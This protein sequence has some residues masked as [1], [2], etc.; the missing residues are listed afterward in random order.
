MTVVSAKSFLDGGGELGQLIREKDWSDTPL[1][2]PSTWPQSLRT[3]IR[4]ILTSR[5]PM[6]VWWGSELINIY[7]DAY[8]SI[9]GGKHP[10]ALGQPASVVWKE[11]WNEVE[12][13]AKTVM[14]ENTGTYDEAL[15]LLMDRNGYV[16]ETYYTFSY[17]PVP[18]DDG[19][20]QGIICAN[21][22]DTRRIMGERQLR[23]LREISKNISGVKTNHEIYQKSLQALEANPQDFPSVALYEI[24]NDGTQMKLVGD[25]YELPKSLAP[26]V[27][28]IEAQKEVYPELWQ[29]IQTGKIQTVSNVIE[30][31]GS[32]NSPFWEESP[33]DVLL[34]PILQP[35]HEFPFALL[36]VGLN[37][38]RL[39]DD[40][41]IDFFNL[42]AD[43]ISTALNNAYA[44]KREQKRAEALA[45]IDQAKTIFFSNISHEFRTPLTLMLGP[46][47]EMLNS[48]AE[49]FTTQDKGNLE[50]THRNAM[51]LLRLVNSLL[52]FSRIEAGR[53]KVKFRGICLGQY[54]ADLASSF[55]SL[56]DKVGLDF[57]I[58]TDVKSAVFVDTD[59]WE[60]IVLN[61]LSNAYKYT[62]S[63]KITVSVIESES[64]VTLTV[65]DTGTGIPESE[66]PHLFERFHRVKNA[67]GRSYE[68]SGIG[69][70][71]VKELVQLNHG[72]ISVQ[73]VEGEGTVFSIQ[74]P[75]GRKHLHDE[76]IATDELPD[77]IVPTRYSEEVLHNVPETD[78]VA[79]PKSNGQQYKILVA[80]DNA[81]MRDY[82]VKLLEKHYNV[83]LAENGKQ[84]LEKVAE[85]SPDLI[86]S[87]IMMPVMDGIEML[88]HVKS[89]PVTKHI[90]VLLLSARAGEEAKIEGYELGA[91]DYLVKPFSAK[92]LLARIHS[93]L[94]MAKTREHIDRQLHNVFMQAPVAICLLRGSDFIVETANQRILDIWGKDAETMLNRPVFEGIPEVARQGYRDLL[95][96]VYNSGETYIAEEM[97]LEVLRNGTAEKIYIKFVYEPFYEEDGTVSG[98]MV[99]AD[100]ITES[101][102][103]RNA[104]QA[105]E[106]RH[107]LAVEAARM[108]SFEWV[109]H[110]DSFIYSNRLAEIFGYAAATSFHHSDFV[111]KIHPDDLVTRNAAVN[112]AMQT[113]LLFYEARIIWDDGSVHWIRLNGKIENDATG[114]P[115]KMFGTVLDITN[116]KLRT[117][118]LQQKVIDRTQSLKEKD[119]ELRVSEER[120]QRMTEEVQDYAIILLDT[121]GT[122]LNWNRG[123]ENIKG[124]NEND[125]VGRSFTIFY[126]PEDQQTRLP[127]RLIAEAALN[128]R[129]TDE[130]YRVRKDGT[131]FWGSISITALHDSENN[132]IGFS[133]VTRDLTERKLSEDRMKKYNAELEFQNRE[134]EQ[135]A[136]I[137]SH[138]L[139]E[140]LRKIQMFTGMLER[141]MG[142]PEAVNRYFEKIN[143]SAE[144]MSDLI[145]AV[146]NYSRLSKTE[147][148][149]VTV[150]I[151]A[152]L[153]NVLTDYELLIEEKGAVVLVDELPSIKAIPL[154]LNQ[155]FSNLIGNAL[156][157]T[158]VSPVL[159]I[160]CRVV[161]NQDIPF[162]TKLPNDVS[163]LELIFSDNGIG[164]DQ[165]Y[166]AQIFTIF[167]RLN[168]RTSFSGTGIGLAL[169]KKIVENHHGFIT[170]RSQAG[171]G[172]S[173]Y[174]YLPVGV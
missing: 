71:L 173:F 104:I 40:D 86:V 74:M 132:V 105:S 57:E 41:Y 157:F 90:P 59:M 150:D 44:L 33:N 75:I 156:K 146:L 39:L 143:S 81:D 167:Q 162:E 12:P 160:K 94:R 68:G 7:N 142:D 92:E 17:S 61:L 140:P 52:D 56:F 145:R 137:A 107:K 25:L 78:P 158:E 110:E 35:D 99:V 47:E 164:F 93:Q 16:E 29:V 42:I 45:E 2:D 141:S 101:V 87:D 85:F 136:Y 65:S 115:A 26:E 48:S 100:D 80:D 138:D 174:V 24:S 13:R 14:E 135:F 43:Q 98:I 97:P 31:F 58:R 127:Q 123:A 169:C 117:S 152:V 155:L 8:K 53:V 15:L 134:L 83:I 22:D 3:S 116:E 113:G 21:T 133:K 154:Q 112:E 69:L 153:Q 79:E 38:H 4:I 119:K 19:T 151:N 120:F 170:A 62:L 172:A 166:A 60:K 165:K 96:Q 6:F 27:I 111:D 51:R 159:T 161:R 18:G 11:I 118:K 122:I 121:D 32:M 91:D 149:F 103:T 126:L 37:P 28:Y 130:G 77:K 124:Y 139:Q 20:T 36:S 129:A 49:N 125:I 144:R 89:D 76:E 10:E 70:S 131:V 63:G 147:D 84:A 54:T 46:I 73:S 95:T 34:L 148:H 67:A 5:Q 66:M 30:R 108:G 163:F 50:I 106:I 9:V 109:F 72:T 82:I 102:T 168:Q 1:G 114:E 128:G 88:Q 55:Q 171:E 64:H 23:T